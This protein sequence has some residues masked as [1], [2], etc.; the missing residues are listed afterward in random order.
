M[1]VAKSLL[2]VLWVACAACIVIDSNA[3]IAV[4]GRL[5]FWALAIA[6]IAEFAM[7]SSVFREAGGSMADH[8][9][10]TLAFGLFHI[11]D[12]RAQLESESSG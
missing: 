7:F 10:K 1:G 12:V 11:R 9:A 3:Q 5:L 6:H 4:A 8:F 2:M